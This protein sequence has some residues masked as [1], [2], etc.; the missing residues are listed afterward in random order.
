MKSPETPE[1]PVFSVVIPVWNEQE[2]LPV[3]HQRLVQT[4]DSTGE[5]WEVIFINDGSKDRS[6]ELLIALSQQDARCLLY[7]SRCV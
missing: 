7:T 6:L 3:L 1:H 5:R 4:M 2:V